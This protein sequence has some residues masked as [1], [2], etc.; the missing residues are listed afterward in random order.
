MLI[1]ILDSAAALEVGA[2]AEEATE[3]RAAEVVEAGVVATAAPEEA[4]VVAVLAPAAEAPEG[5]RSAQAK[6]TEILNIN[7]PG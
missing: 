2:E 5:A 1:L 6:C 7:N 4:L 3:G